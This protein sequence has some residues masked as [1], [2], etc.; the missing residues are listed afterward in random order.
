MKNKAHFKK[1]LILLQILVISVIL[2]MLCVTLL[3]LIL[4]RH[5]LAAKMLRSAKAKTYSDAAFARNVP[6][7]NFVTP[8]NGNTSIPIDDK[9]VNINVSGSKITTTIEQD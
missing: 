9:T 1:G 7:C 8:V 3:K 6:N 4:G 5:L 2:S